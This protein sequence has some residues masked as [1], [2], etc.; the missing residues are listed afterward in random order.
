MRTSALLLLALLAT[1]CTSTPVTRHYPVDR[2]PDEEGGAYVAPEP[3]SSAPT[4]E[5]RLTV[6]GRII[7][8]CP[9]A[10]KPVVGRLVQL[11][12]AESEPLEATTD[13]RGGFVLTARREKTS[14]V[15]RTE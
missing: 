15:F 14:L 6:Y 1:S 5:R 2:E 13:Q 12:L 7:E 9:V 11:S 10:D 8:A 4:V 3:L